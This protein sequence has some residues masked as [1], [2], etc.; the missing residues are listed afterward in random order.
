[1]KRIY[2]LILFLSVFTSSVLFAQ[3]QRFVCG[4]NDNALSEETLK[5]MR[6]APTWLAEK[7][8]RKATD[9]LYV[10]RLGID[11]DSDTYNFFNKD[12]V[13]IKFELLKM[14]E[15][16]SSIYEAEINT[17]LLVTHINIR[18]DETTDPYKGISDIFRLINILQNNWLEAPF[19]KLPVDKVMYLPTKAFT[20]AGGVATDR[21]N[22]S[23]WGNINTIAHELGHNL[24][25]PHTQSCEWPGGPLDKCYFPEGDCYQNSLEFIRGTIMS[26]CSGLLTFHP[27][28]RVVMQNYAQNELQKISKSPAAPVV[29]DQ[30]ELKGDA[31]FIFD[32]SPFAENYLYE[33]S[34]TSDFSQK[35][36]ADSS[37]INAF[38]YPFFRKNTT[39]YIRVKARNRHGASGWS[40]TG[41]VVVPDNILTAPVLRKP[42]NLTPDNPVTDT[43]EELTLPFD[44][45]DGA[46]SYELDLYRCDDKFT[47]TAYD[48][49]PS[50]RYSFAFTADDKF[51]ISPAKIGIYTGL[52]WRVRALKD[53]INGAWSEMQGLLFSKMSENLSSVFNNKEQM[54][55]T[56]PLTYTNSYSQLDIELK[57]TVSTNE[58]YSKPVLEK[59]VKQDEFSTDN[60]TSILVENLLP[61]TRYYAK[62]DIVNLK[63]DRVYN[64][65][66]GVRKTIPF[67]FKTGNND[68]PPNWKI[69]NQDNAPSMGGFQ[70]AFLMGQS[71]LFSQSERGISKLQVNDFKTALYNLKNSGGNLSNR[72]VAMDIDSSGNFWSVIAL[73]KRSQSNAGFYPPPV[74]A[75]RK[76]DERTMKLISSE[77]FVAE[78]TLTFLG[79]FDAD[80]KLMVY[81]QNTIARIESNKLK[82]ILTLSNFLVLYVASTDSY[83]YIVGEN[84]TTHLR[85]VL[86]YNL[87]TKEKTSLGFRSYYSRAKLDKNKRLWTLINNGI[88]RFEGTEVTSY[89]GS[90]SSLRPLYNFDDFFI[91]SFDN[92]YAVSRSIYPNNKETYF[93]KFDGI[94]WKE[95]GSLP[96][97]LSYYG[98]LM[99]DK[100]GKIWFTSSGREL[101]RFDPCTSL[102]RPTLRANTGN[103]LLEAQGCASV[104]W[105]WKNKEENVYEKLVSGTNKIEVSP[106]STT[107]YYARCY[108]NGCSGEEDSFAISFYNLL[109]GKVVK[110][111]ICQGDSIE[112]SPQI[113]G[114]FGDKNQLSAVLTSSGNN[115]NIPLVSR[116]NRYGFKS[117]EHIPVGKYW[118]KIASTHPELISK[119]STEIEILSKPIVSMA[120]KDNICPG[121]S[122]SINATGKNGTAPY[123]YQWKINNVLSPKDESIMAKIDKPG[124]I[125][126]KAIDSKGCVSNEATLNVTKSNF[127]NLKIS[128]GGSTD[129]INNASVVLSVPSITS[130]V[131]Q[132][133]RDNQAIQGA[134]NN[135]YNTSQAGSYYV[136]ASEKGCT[137]E[138]N[139]VAVS[140]ITAN[141]PAASDEL[142]LKVFPNPS[143]G[144][145]VFEIILKD[146]VPLEL[147]VFD[148]AGKTIWQKRIKGIGKHTEQLNLSKHATGTYLLTGQKDNW[149]QT[150]K[151]EKQ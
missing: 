95:I 54:P 42:Y 149:K 105:N 147:S 20:G 89:E 27:M 30:P 125:V 106:K 120:G 59:T 113:E 102:I 76:F 141:E 138:S 72:Q 67:N 1:M 124:I 23:P 88:Q 19:D 44:L 133:Y 60:N 136:K 50:S 41:R 85:E 8:T 130:Y 87:L 26:Y 22:V 21:I 43:A 97:G 38:Y 104:V 48:N 53:G 128:A 132:W 83:V 78:F 17:Q 110:N 84:S 37:K 142:S 117:D 63:D 57:F 18:K 39:Y 94:E 101:I 61:A 151:L 25:S 15:K 58:D 28:C 52:M 10:C 46:S 90:K 121:Q 81:N 109:T 40:K 91:D 16:V 98:Y 14:I 33:V 123:I 68:M 118:L 127:D 134:T 73:S 107:T 116:S 129:L 99:A 140:L 49:Y 31:R 79:F 64:I 3:N 51:L 111:E 115:F 32:A 34:E 70:N 7:Q 55:L 148:I 112:F 137:G 93:H 92:V 74:Y 114:I 66:L 47:Y 77:E 122:I 36:Y 139:I 150:I 9:E 80:S 86:K 75:I 62:L 145:F 100:S 126:V 65:P 131:Y 45:V 96:S 103:T 13:F 2:T 82:P 4:F 56:F 11:I 119:D 35:V 24:A 146:N 144:N 12:T 6:M 69:F 71:G 29:P 143:D 5:A 135:G 108:D